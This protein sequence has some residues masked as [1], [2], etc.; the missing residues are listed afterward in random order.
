V[1][2]GPSGVGKNTVARA[3]S[4]SGRAVRAVTATTRPPRPGER[5]GV[6]YYFVSRERFEDWLRQ[7]LLLE[8]TRYLGHCYGTP[9]FS[10]NRAAESGLPVLLVVDV[11][12]ALALKRRWPAL[13]LVFLALPDE[14]DLARRLRARGAEDEQSIVRRLE[15]ARREMA[16]RERYDW[17][18]V[19]DNVEN[20]VE[21]IA[22]IIEANTP[23]GLARQ[24]G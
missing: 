11:N 23:P 10:V 15:R 24:E 9:A 14:E 21:Q 22:G 7:G 20:A 12:G 6:D 1:L 13:R 16:F 5:D 17:T 2:S 19:N 18:V 8:H 4:E 3:L